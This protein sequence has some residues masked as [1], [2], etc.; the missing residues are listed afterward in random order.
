MMHELVKHWEYAGNLLPQSLIVGRKSESFVRLSKR[1][2]YQNILWS[3]TV[4]QDGFITE[5]G[6]TSVGAR[7]GNSQ[8][9]EW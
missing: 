1:W 5:N 9:T 2:E 6:I 8:C 7:E 4:P 3:Q